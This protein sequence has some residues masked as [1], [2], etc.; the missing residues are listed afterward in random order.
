VAVEALRR[1]ERGRLGVRLAVVFGSILR[2]PRARDVDVSVF[3]DEGQT[4]TR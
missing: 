2:S 4:R 1:V 3:V